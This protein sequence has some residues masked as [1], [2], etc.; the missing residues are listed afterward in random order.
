MCLTLAVVLALRTSVPALLAG[1]LLPAGLAG[2]GLLESRVGSPGLSRAM[3]LTVA[4]PW[5]AGL[6]AACASLASLAA[7]LLLLMVQVADRYPA[8]GPTAGASR[9]AE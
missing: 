9:A 4:P 5:S 7:L 8:P 1:M 6:T 3:Q 2:A